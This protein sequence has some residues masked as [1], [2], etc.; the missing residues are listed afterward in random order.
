MVRDCLELWSLGVG[1]GMIIN[2]LG[3]S[4]GFRESGRIKELDIWMRFYNRCN[5]GK[6]VRYGEN[7]KDVL[8]REWIRRFKS[9]E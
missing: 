1:A 9:L 8:V 6:K 5:K 7:R 4:Y 3:D 2:E